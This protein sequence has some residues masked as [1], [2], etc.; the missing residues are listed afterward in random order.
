MAASFPELC[1]TAALAVLCASASASA[2]DVPIQLDAA[3]TDFD[4]RNQRL[5]FEQ[6]SIRRGPLGI[7]ADHADSSQL[8]FADSTWTFRGNV[9]IDSAQAAVSAAQATLQFADH[10]LRRATVEGGPAV[11]THRAD[12]QVRVT[13]NRAV[14][15]FGTEELSKI[16]LTGAPAEFAHT[17]LRP[18]RTVTRGHAAEIVYDLDTARI[19]LAGDAWV[20]QGDNEIRGEQIVYDIEAERVVAGGDAAGDRVRITITPPPAKDDSQQ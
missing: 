5:L 8:D 3:S 13:A 10:R 4:R 6:V 14:V 7:S 20:S 1:R 16:T 11:L 18:Q 17:A 15:E 12:A 2:Q 9:R 19:R